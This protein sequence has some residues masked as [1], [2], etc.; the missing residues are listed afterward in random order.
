MTN[1]V[2]KVSIDIRPNSGFNSIMHVLTIRSQIFLN[3]ITENFDDFPL[4]V[5]SK[6]IFFKKADLLEL[7]NI[8]RR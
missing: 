6:R 1:P 3:L 5:F 4:Q 8:L 2:L 7:T